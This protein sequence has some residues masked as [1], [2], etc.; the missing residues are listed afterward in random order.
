ML[1]LK[2]HPAL[3]SERYGGGEGEEF[4][5]DEDSTVLLALFQTK[6][7]SHEESSI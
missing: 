4:R 2:H 7:S 3:H 1:V 6:S 5:G